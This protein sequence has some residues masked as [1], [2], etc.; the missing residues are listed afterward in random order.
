MLHGGGNTSM[1]G[2]VK[3]V[4]DQVEKALFVKGS[5]WDLSSIEAEG[6]PAVGFEQLLKLAQLPGLSDSEMMRQLR[7]GLFDPS[8]PT[9]SVEAILH[10]LIPFKYVDH[11]HADAVVTISNS[12]DGDKLLHQLYGDEV[13]ILPY[14]MPGFILARQVADTTRHVDWNKLRGIVLLH[15]GLFTFADDP[16]QS[17]DTMIELVDAAEGLLDQ[18]CPHSQAFASCTPDA[19]DYL[20]LAELR[21]AAGELYGFPVLLHLDHSP[22]AAGFANLTDAGALLR[23]G[24][25]TPDH[26]IH[27]KAFGAELGDEPLTGLASFAERYREYFRDHAVD[28]Q[29]C[30]DL[31]PRYAV[32]QQRGMVYFAPNAK[33]LRIVRDIT[34]HT[35]RAIQQAE[36]LGGWEALSRPELFAVEYWELEQAK[37][38]KSGERP[39]LE[40]RVAL[41]TGAAAGIG[42]A[43]MERLLDLGAAVIALDSNTDFASDHPA[44]LA[45]NCDVIDAAAVQSALM[46]GLVL[47]GGVDMVISNAGSFPVSA[48][49]ESVHDADWE[50]SLAVNLSAPMA[51]LRACIPFLKQGFDPAVVMVG[52]KNVPAPGPGAA[53]Y[54]VAKAGQTQLARVAALELGKHGIRVN[55]VHPNAVYDTALW[56]EERLAERAAHYGLSVEDYRS[57]NVLHREIVAADVARVIVHLAGP[58]F[59]H[60]TGAQIP[61]DGGNERVI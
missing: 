14:I 20:C 42:R 36:A 7:L 48:P 24:P 32:W 27:V 50:Q 49:I 61:V 4:F 47:F 45:V 13:L 51:L 52:S 5:G 46:S 53:A 26:S 43:C 23:R 57:N 44:C 37:L 30:L 12:P 10:A 35:L 21:R 8:A 17:Y 34:R 41:V 28:G 15:H 40:G 1:K 31:M 22:E 33:R 38:R 2:D 58:D 6:F 29:Q 55:T 9:P 11:S 60:T 19:E 56:S 3:N 39:E 59:I 54:S 16:Q 18:R 25:L